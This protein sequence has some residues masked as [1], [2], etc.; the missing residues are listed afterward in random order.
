MQATLGEQ[1][2]QKMFDVIVMGAKKPLFMRTEGVFYEFDSY[3][4]DLKG[5]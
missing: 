5:P 1:N 4:D 2:W 3:K